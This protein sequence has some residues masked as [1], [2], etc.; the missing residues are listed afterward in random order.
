MKAEDSLA[1]LRLPSVNHVSSLP[2]KCCSIAHS[3]TLPLRFVCISSHM[4]LYTHRLS[5]I[6]AHMHEHILEQTEPA[7]I[8][9]LISFLTINDLLRTVVLRSFMHCTCSVPEL[10]YFMLPPST[11]TI[12]TYFLPHTYI[13]TQ[14]LSF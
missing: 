10:F 1:P 14:D 11:L 3:P 7:L 13:R 6:H 2:E 9:L 12:Y 4:S 5:K 8:Q